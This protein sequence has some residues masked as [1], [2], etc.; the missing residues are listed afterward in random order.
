MT[1][2]TAR[3]G[4][5]GGNLGMGILFSLYDGFT[6]TSKQ[7]QSEFNRLTNTADKGSNSIEGSLDRIYG[8]MA[9]IGAGVALMLPFYKAVKDF[10]TFDGLQRGLTAVMHSAESANAEIVKLRE[11][12]KLP[13]LNFQEALSGST[14]LQAAGM[15]AMLARRSLMAFG[16]A[17]STVGKGSAELK[18]V[19]LALSQIMS[20][21]KVSAEEINQLNERVPQIRQAMKDA[22]GTS[23]TEKLGKMGVTSEIFIEG[24]VKQ[25]EKLPKVTGGIGNAMEN[26]Q[27]SIWRASVSVGKIL[28]PAVSF[29][30]DKIGQL[31]DMIEKLAA[32][33]LGGL[34][35]KMAAIAT[36]V[37]ASTLAFSGLKIV[38]GDTIKDSIPYFKAMAKGLKDMWSSFSFSIKGFIEL[39]KSIH[40]AF[41]SNPLT[42]ALIVMT[43]A[44]ME[45]YKGFN[46]F[47][48]LL[49]GKV[50]VLSGY[51]GWL[52]RMGGYLHALGEIFSTVTSEGWSMSYALEE[53]L[54]QMGILDNVIA[55]GTGIVRL[56][57]LTEGFMSVLSTTGDMLSSAF[58]GIFSVLNWLGLGF[59]KNLSS[60]E[61]WKVAGQILAVVLVGAI[62][63]VAGS[64][65]S[66]G[67]A[68]AI[69][70]A[71]FIFIG[72]LIVWLGYTIGDTFSWLYDVFSV[73]GEGIA[74]FASA[75]VDAIIWLWNSIPDFGAKAYEIGVEFVEFLTMGI[76]RDWD[77]LVDWLKS[78]WDNIKSFFGE[79][80]SVS[81]KADISDMGGGSI[82]AAPNNNEADRYNNRITVATAPAAAMYSAPPHIID[83]STQTIKNVS[84][85]VTL[86]GREIY[87]NQNDI[88]N[89]EESRLGL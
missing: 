63:L 54:R 33:P 89:M 42:V 86:D 71:P 27:D 49:S 2:G 16:S 75:A 74:A 47:S 3:A 67:V 37:V 78:A 18:G 12:A 83:K 14:N 11:V 31:A 20:K 10:A 73:L 64:L 36:T 30:A 55:L 77:K 28:A 52:Q 25:L 79:S 19:N 58:D 8:G 76:K 88:S 60:L 80:F 65:I 24:I 34:I 57:A 51:A 69:A 29:I 6:S 17:L 53:S 81:A 15:S 5:D 70:W 22:F 21:G 61:K 41:L 26:V 85:T 32:T 50:G 1:T 46:S 84:T 23:D 38:F 4:G 9:K 82:S 43:V 72:G 7:I 44:V 40:T 35:I 66:A 56:T 13:G 59:E 87:R 68:A 62:A 48:D 39:G 45:L